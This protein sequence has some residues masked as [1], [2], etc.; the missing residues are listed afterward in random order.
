MTAAHLRDL[1]ASREH[2]MK[3]GFVR[4]DPEWGPGGKIEGEPDRSKVDV[5]ATSFVDLAEQ[6]GA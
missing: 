6:L 4:R 3:T 2:G 5:V 1:Y